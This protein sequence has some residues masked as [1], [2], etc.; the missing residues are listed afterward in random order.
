MAKQLYERTS[1]AAQ[2]D[3][4]QPPERFMSAFRWGVIGLLL[5]AALGQETGAVGL[6]AGAVIGG[7]GGGL[8]GWMLTV[9]DDDS[10]PGG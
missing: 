3:R 4:A 9:Y 5:G 8:T 10:E 2:P 7:V 6:V 1:P